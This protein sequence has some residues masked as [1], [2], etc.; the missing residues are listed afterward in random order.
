MSSGGGVPKSAGGGGVP[1]SAGGGV[2]KSAGGGGVPK[3]AG[4]GV[5]KSAGGGVPKSTGGGV[6]F[7]VFSMNFFFCSPI[8][9]IPSSF[10]WRTL[11][12]LTIKLSLFK[13][14]E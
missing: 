10:S 5:P 13:A 11:I 12:S 3:S 8:S 1:K 6:F 7:L 4:G 14:C 2:P 9:E